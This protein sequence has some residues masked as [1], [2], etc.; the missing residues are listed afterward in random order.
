MEILPKLFGSDAKVKI[1]RLFLN[2]PEEVFVLQDIAKR[3]NVNHSAAK[4]QIQDMREIGFIKPDIK[5]IIIEFKNKKQKKTKIKGFKL[6]KFFPYYWSL[7]SLIL[8][9]APISKENIIK[10]LKPGGRLSLVILSGAFV[11]DEKSP[12]DI[13]IVGDRLSKSHLEK[14]VKSIEAAVSRELNYSI[15]TNDEFKYRYNMHDRF[16]YD[17]LDSPHEKILNKL[18][19]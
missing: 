10:R 5:E 7:K 3:L 6:N 1:L 15:M 13:L 12:L 16:L 9:T 18:E 2:M 17:V 8:D 14:S 19:I 4:K 11:R